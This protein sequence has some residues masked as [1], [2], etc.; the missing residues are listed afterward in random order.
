MNRKSIH[1]PDGEY[2][3]QTHI[4]L[5]LGYT[6]TART[7][8]KRSPFKEKLNPFRIGRLVVYRKEDNEWLFNKIKEKNHD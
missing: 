8:L 5:L 2:Y 4:L 3:T 6:E 7:I 1:I